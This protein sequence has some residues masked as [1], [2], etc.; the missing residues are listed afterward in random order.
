VPGNEMVKQK[1]KLENRAHSR[2]S[3]RYWGGGW[4]LAL[5]KTGGKHR[6]FR[7]SSVLTK[8]IKSN[9]DGGSA[10]IARWEADKSGG[11][12]SFHKKRKGSSI[13]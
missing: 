4:S 6:K 8:K 13:L 7:Q 10:I 5:K 3:K 1:G 11:G 2:Q 9:K 12:T